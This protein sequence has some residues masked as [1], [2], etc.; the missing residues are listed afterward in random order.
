MNL[1]FNFPKALD[2]LNSAI[3]GVGPKSVIKTENDIAFVPLASWVGVPSEE[4]P[5]NKLTRKGR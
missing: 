3:V 5:V 2:A 1:A 4:Y